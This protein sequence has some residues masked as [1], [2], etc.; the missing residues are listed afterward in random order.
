MTCDMADALLGMHVQEIAITVSSSLLQG[1]PAAA[2][3]ST[4][5]LPGKR[6]RPSARRLAYK[7][8]DPTA[9]S[10]W[11]QGEEEGVEVDAAAPVR[12]GYAAADRQA[13][14]VP[15]ITADP[16]LQAQ[17]LSGWTRLGADGAAAEPGSGA[18]GE[19]DAAGAAGALQQGGE[20]VGG[21]QQQ[22]VEDDFMEEEEW[23]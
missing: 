4:Q 22:E 11:L 8:P 21:Q 20:G 14:A 17:Q 1:E 18:G 6:T 2:E 23:I 15:R 10:K 16:L 12:I 13:A 9:V 7:P 19:Q 3:A 5:P